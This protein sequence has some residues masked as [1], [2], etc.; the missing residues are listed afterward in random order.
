MRTIRR[1]QLRVALALVGAT[2]LGCASKPREPERSA[3]G[4]V[5]MRVRGPGN[6]FTDPAHAIDDYDAVWVAG[7]GIHLAAGQEPMPDEETASLRAAIAEVATAQV[8]A[9]GAP[10]AQAPG[11]CTVKLIAY[12]ANLDLPEPTVTSARANGGM[13]VILELRDSETNAPLVRYGRPRRLDRLRGARGP[14][15]LERLT[16]AVQ[17]ALDASGFPLRDVLP[18][19]RTH[20]RDAQGCHGALGDL[21]EHPGAGR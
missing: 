11:A 10:T 15:R 12:L 4:L 16:A 13:I 1:L 6:L 18:V 9:A 2:A 14:E 3:D 19:N 8:A 21:R 17:E 20:A 7:A 5:R